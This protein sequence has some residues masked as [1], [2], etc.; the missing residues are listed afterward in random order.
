MKKTKRARKVLRKAKQAI[1]PAV[2]LT[3]EAARKVYKD[4]KAAHK[5][6]AKVI[7]KGVSP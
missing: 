5:A 2:K 3:R 1:E 6:T 4:L 7:R